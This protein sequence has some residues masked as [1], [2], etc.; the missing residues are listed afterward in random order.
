MQRPSTLSA[1]TTT[2]GALALVVV[3]CSAPHRFFSTEGAG[4]GQGAGAAG[5][6][7]E[8]VITTSSSGSSASSSASNSSST[9]STSSGAGGA[10]GAGGA[11]PVVVTCLSSDAAQVPELTLQDPRMCV[12]AVYDAPERFNY[13]ADATFTR[14]PTW[15]RH[16]GPLTVAPSGADV[17]LERWQVPATPTGTLTKQET[18]V[19]AGIPTASVTLHTAAYDVPFFGW[20]AVAYSNSD[21]Q[22][23]GEIV[24]IQGAAVA[25]RYPLV[26][27]FSA[28]GVG[29]GGSGR[30]LHL[31]GSKLGD[32]ASSTY[33][34]FAADTCGGARLVPAGDTSCAP[35]SVVGTWGSFSTN[36]AADLDGN[37][38]ISMSDFNA[39]TAAIQGF[40]ASAIGRGAP[41]TQ[42]DLI[43][44]AD[45]FGSGVAAMAPTR[46][47]DGVVVSQSGT[48]ATLGAPTVLSR[49]YTVD[50]GTIS[51][52][53]DAT[54]LLTL[55]DTSTAPVLFTDDLGQLWAAINIASGTGSRLVVI[56]RR[57]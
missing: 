41:P 6:G 36:V 22:T 1:N 38:F 28:V 24:L 30:L 4:G 26:N 11:P 46:D 51:P 44:T 42:G 12:V 3:A 43:M 57:P 47:A 15:G 16:G 8:D 17:K 18:T 21:F 37:V 40:A 31:G 10:G 39:G 50:A 49:F 35:P 33:G 2:L 9:S 56:A 29:S 19:E 7:G 48:L 14:R 52:V 55:S 20:T 27:I 34:F 32:S 23:A 45:G 5:G 54:T 53:G 13:D 25:T